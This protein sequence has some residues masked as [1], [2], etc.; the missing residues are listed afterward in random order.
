MA[1]LEARLG[2]IEDGHEGL[3][4]GDL[5]EVEAR[6]ER[7][8]GDE[9]PAAAAAVGCL[10]SRLVDLE[11]A[12]TGLPTHYD[13]ERALDAGLAGVPREEDLET[14]RQVVGAGLAEVPREE[15]WAAVRQAAAGPSME[16][17]RAELTAAM[18]GLVTA[19]DLQRE[20]ATLRRGPAYVRGAGAAM[21]HAVASAHPLL[22]P[23]F[24]E[25]RCGWA[26]GGTPGV[27]RFDVEPAITYRAKGQDV[28]VRRCDKC[29]QSMT[30]PQQ[31]APEA[32]GG[33]S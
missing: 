12:V 5:S 8:E 16:A 4:R 9:A 29:W 3:R 20:M 15:D 10:D 13:V 30:I 7:L 24:H 1:A 11:A 2:L 26:F 14:V 32:G 25:T 19:G 33:Q 6:L 31:P 18:A 22:E 17:V 27:Q 21:Y 23:L 28:Q